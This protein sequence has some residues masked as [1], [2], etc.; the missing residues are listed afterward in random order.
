MRQAPHYTDRLHPCAL[1]L[2]ASV[3]N[4]TDGAVFGGREGVDGRRCVAF[5]VT[6]A[7][8]PD[9]RINLHRQTALTARD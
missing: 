4:R 5:A 2:W 3:M 9:G 8:G 1:M 7:A 6:V